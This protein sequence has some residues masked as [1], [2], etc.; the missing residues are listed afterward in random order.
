MIEIYKIVSGK[1]DSSV[2]PVFKLSDFTETS[3][4]DVKVETARIHYDL[5]RYSFTNRVINIW[6][7]LPNDIVK[8][9]TV[10]QFKNRLDKFW[11][12]QDMIYNYKADLIGIGGQSRV[13]V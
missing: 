4:N 8:A 7:S 12:N 2:A 9:C 10:N 1:Y 5:R 11:K 3:G 13:D 6:N